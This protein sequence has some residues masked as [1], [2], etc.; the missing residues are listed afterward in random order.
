MVSTAQVAYDK[1]HGMDHAV[2]M[3]SW[4]VSFVAY[5]RDL[6]AA[7]KLAYARLIEMRESVGRRLIFNKIYAAAHAG[8]NEKMSSLIDLRSRF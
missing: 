6:V 2:V 8:V 3:N 5:A 1:T 4:Y 7:D